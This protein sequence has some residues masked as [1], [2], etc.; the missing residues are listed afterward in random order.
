MKIVEKQFKNFRPSPGL[1]PL[2]SIQYF[3]RIYNS[4]KSA[5]WVPRL[6]NSE[7]KAQ[8]IE[9]ARD[10]KCRH[11]CQGMAFFKSVVTMDES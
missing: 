6:L 10:L 11:F 3:T 2:P 5:R 8:Q 7:H 9:M 1:M 4:K